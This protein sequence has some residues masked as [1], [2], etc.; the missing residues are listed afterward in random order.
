MLWRP[1]RFRAA[2]TTLRTAASSRR[3]REQLA[4]V[5]DLATF[6]HQAPRNGSSSSA[7]FARL[8]GAGQLTRSG[9]RG[10]VGLLLCKANQT[11][12]TG[13][14]FGRRSACRVSTI[15]APIILPE[16]AF[17]ECRAGNAESNMTRQVAMRCAATVLAKVANR[18]RSDRG[19]RAGRFASIRDPKQGD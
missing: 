9:V 19:K 17:G 6:L 8:S 7:R 12:A 1:Q 10:T 16:G 18:R 2:P 15:H 5:P 4:N 11:G 3:S 14:W 13:S